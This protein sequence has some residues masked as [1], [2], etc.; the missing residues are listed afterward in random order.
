VTQAAFPRLPHLLR[1]LGLTLVVLMALQL[2]ALLLSW[3]WDLEPFRQLFLDRLVGE[4]PMALVGLLLML[5]A[6]RLE[7]G[8][9]RRTLLRWLAG[10]LAVLLAIAMAVAVPLSVE[11][12]G[13]VLAQAEQQDAAI[14][15]QAAQ[16]DLQR[17]QVDSPGFVDELIAEAEKEGRIPANASKEEKQQKAKEFIDSQIRPQLEQAEKQVAQAMLGRDLA[18]QQRRFGGTGRAIV[19]AVAFALVALAALV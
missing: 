18:V 3:N 19:L 8:A 4:A 1:W 11:L 2:L 14:G 13:S 12:E 15:Q 7:G 5:T 6:Q 17:Q 9:E 16:L 10:I